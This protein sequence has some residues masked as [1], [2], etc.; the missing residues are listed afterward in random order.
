MLLLR[1]IQGV[2]KIFGQNSAASFPKNNVEKFHIDIRPQTLRF[3]GTFNNNF[4]PN[5]K[6][7]FL[8][9]P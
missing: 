9:C 8:G 6:D 4:D 3:R 7:F 5:A 2:P 1:D